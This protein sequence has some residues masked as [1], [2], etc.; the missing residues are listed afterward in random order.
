MVDVVKLTDRAVA[1]GGHRLIDAQTDR[2]HRLGVKAT[3]KAVHLM[4]PAPEVLPRPGGHALADPA[5]IELKRM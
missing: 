2:L 1:G 5:Q 4:T 3:R